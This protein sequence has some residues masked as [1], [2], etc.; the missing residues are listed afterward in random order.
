MLRGTALK[1]TTATETTA[2]IATLPE[3]C[4]D[5]FRLIRPG[6]T[7]PRGKDGTVQCPSCAKSLLIG[8]DFETIRAIG[9]LAV[10]Y[11]DSLIRLRREGAAITIASSEIRHL[12]NE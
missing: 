5:C 10:E 2:L 8:E 1:Q 11:G 9:E 12:A 7:Y 6:E 3:Y 4:R